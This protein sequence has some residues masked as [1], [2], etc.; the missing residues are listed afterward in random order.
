MATLS[1]LPLNI[2]DP[3]TQTGN[4]TIIAFCSL[5]RFRPNQSRRVALQAMWRWMIIPA[6]FVKI[7]TRMP[8]GWSK[9]C[10]RSRGIHLHDIDV[11]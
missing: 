10:W 7:D 5:F 6:V 8:I 11:N 2:I 9:Q 4:P 1:H 3:A